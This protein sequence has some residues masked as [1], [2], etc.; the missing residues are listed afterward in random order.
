[1]KGFGRS[2]VIRMERRPIRSGDQVLR[3]VSDLKP[4]HAGI[5]P[6]IFYIDRE[7]DDNV[8]AIS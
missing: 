2:H 4:T 3:F 8:A 1:M 5:D 7:E 6:Y